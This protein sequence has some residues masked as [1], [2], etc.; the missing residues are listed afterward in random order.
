M[1]IEPQ[2]RTEM[3]DRT[4]SARERLGRMAEFEAALAEAQAECGV[5][6]AEAAAVVAKVARSADL[7]ADAVFA[8]AL[9]AGNPAIPFVK[10]YTAAVE[11]TSADAARFVHF[12]STSQ[13]VIDSAL[14]LGLARIADAIDADLTRCVEDLRR[15]ALAHARTPMAARTL[16][17]QGTPI[18]F[19]FKVGTWMMAAH[20]A[21][22]M[23]RIARREQCAV[24]LG[25]ATGNLGAMGAQGPAVRAAVARRLD[26]ADPEFCWHTVRDRVVGIGNG[27]AVVLGAAAKIAG[28][29]VLLMQSE[30][31]EVRERSGAG[32]GGSSAMPHKRNPVDA[33]VAIAALNNGAGLMAALVVGQ[34]QENERAAGAWHG[35]WTSLSVL[36]TLA[37]ASAERLRDL[38]GGLEIDTVE[39][40]ANLDLYHGLL[41]AE[42]LGLALTESHGRTKAHDIVKELSGRLRDQGGDLFTLAS[43]DPRVTSVLGPDRLTAIFRHD[44]AITA[45]AAELDR[46]VA[47]VDREGQ[48][49]APQQQAT[50]TPA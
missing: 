46:M 7:D 20:R 39:M 28:D 14:M 16:L 34:R 37:A 38:V 36:S 10:Q 45:S 23:L 49:S 30:I 2:F 8:A 17:Q 22:R 40:A 18:S 48:G 26:L 33:L 42:E 50:E 25:G 4:W 35:E 12:G 21:R 13:D 6:P 47:L 43:A 15:L 5:I 31:G 41:A 19:G 1:L 11:R 27:F 24:Q 29:V 3:A 44:S 32:R 9:Q